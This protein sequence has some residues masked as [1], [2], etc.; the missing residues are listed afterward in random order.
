MLNFGLTDTRIFDPVI[1][2]GFLIAATNTA[3]AGPR[4]LGLAHLAHAEL[5]DPVAG[6]PL[7][8]P[9]ARLLR[10]TGPLPCPVVWVMKGGAVVVDT[11][12]RSPP[13][14]SLP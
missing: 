1:S 7:P 8:R 2:N 14:T 13:F 10:V 4:A 6:L 12:Q 9:R 3:G 5:D 11:I